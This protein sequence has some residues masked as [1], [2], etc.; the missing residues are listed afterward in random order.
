MQEIEVKING[1][2]Q[3]VGLRR[4]IEKFCKDSKI[5]GFIINEKDGGV[6]I[7]VQ[8][9]KKNLNELIIFIQKNPGFSKITELNYRFN[10]PTK[11]YSNFE[12]IKDKNFIIDQTK[13]F[14]NLGKYLFKDKNPKVPKHVAIIPDGN[15]RWAKLKGKEETFG[16]YKSANYNNLKALFDE[17][18][19]QGVKYISIWGFSTENWKRKSEEIN[20]IFN[21]ILGF[22]QKY[23]SDLHKNKTRFRHLGRKDKLPKKLCQELIR[24][25]NETKN[26][27]NFN[28]QLCLDYGGKDEIIRAINKLLKNKEKK[29]NEKTFSDYLDTKNIPDPDLIIRT[30]G[31]KRLSGFMPFQSTYA[32]IYFTDKHFPDFNTIELKKALN[33]FSQ[34]K[35]RF[36]GNSLK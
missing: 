13:S 12:V 3:G 2:V 16:H 22:I 24:L 36:G 21:L 4:S 5:N 15:R 8:G 1:K 17:A 32:E 34:R 14:F 10:K 30:S 29:V 31:E 25:E 20:A 18:R 11:K 26:Y 27:R 35:R 6:F 23:E 7:T 19:E 33:D 9:E 28:I